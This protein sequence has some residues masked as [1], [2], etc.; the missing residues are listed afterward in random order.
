MLSLN[1]KSEKGVSLFFAILILSSVLAISFGISAILFSQ[2][3]TIAEVGRSVVAFFT[4]DAG[5]ENGLFSLYK[6]NIAP[7]YQISGY[8]DLNQNGIQDSRD[9]NFTVEVMGGENC[10]ARFFCIKSIGSY[11]DTNRSIEAKY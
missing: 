6:E 8:L 3:K 7:P 10:G 2:I 11:S 4:A 5:I 9:P 1:L